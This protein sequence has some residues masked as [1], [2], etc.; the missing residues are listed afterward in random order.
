MT[1][2]QQHDGLESAGLLDYIP[3][4]G[5]IGITRVRES[6][7]AGRAKWTEWERVVARPLARWRQSYAGY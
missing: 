5:P 4:P 6:D 7:K 1:G 3:F 2:Y